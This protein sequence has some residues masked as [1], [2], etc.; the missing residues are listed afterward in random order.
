MA[1]ILHL[2]KVLN[3]RIHYEGIEALEKGLEKG[4]VAPS[5]YIVDTV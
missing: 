1:E 5:A 3:N 4:A 2:E